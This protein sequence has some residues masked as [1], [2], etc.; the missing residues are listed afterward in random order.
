MFADLPLNFHETEVVMVVEE[1][2]V[3]HHLMMI[4]V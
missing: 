1:E 4:E 3:V 2:V